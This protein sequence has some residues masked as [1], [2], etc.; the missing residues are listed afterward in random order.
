LLN[1]QTLIKQFFAAAKPL[2]SDKIPE[3]GAFCFVDVW[4]RP[5]TTAW[6]GGRPGKQIIGIRQFNPEGELQ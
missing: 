5:T 2:V 1:Y 6:G 4:T 3:L